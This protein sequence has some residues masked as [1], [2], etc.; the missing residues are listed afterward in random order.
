QFVIVDHNIDYITLYAHLS[1]VLVNEGDVVA[2]GQP[3]GR[4]GSSGNST[5]PHLHFEVRDFGQRVDPI[6]LLVR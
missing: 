6:Q 4:V 2:Q 1:E 5:G 3:I